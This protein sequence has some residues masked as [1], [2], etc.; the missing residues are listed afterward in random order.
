MD[1]IIERDTEG[2]QNRSLTLEWAM[3]ND[4]VCMNTFFQKAL[5][6]LTT[7]REKTT[8]LETR[9]WENRDEYAQIDF[10]WA[11]QRWNKS[12]VNIET[13]PAS[14]FPSDHFPLTA[15]VRLRLEERDDLEEG[16]NVK[17]KGVQKP[18]H[19]QKIVGNNKRMKHLHPSYPTL[20]NEAL[21]KYSVD[22]H[23]S[24]SELVENEDQLFQK[25]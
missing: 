25:T 19:V 5:D 12:I 15:I 8:D 23:D 17:W 13:D 21:D 22:F 4:L 6:K 20:K 1:K 10:L 9:N 18:Y 3:E 14:N 16:L 11:Q 2:T 7:F 24:F